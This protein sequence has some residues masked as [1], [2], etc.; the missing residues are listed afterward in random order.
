MVGEMVG[1]CSV[2]Q[3]GMR[4]HANLLERLK[5]AIDRGQRQGRTTVSRDCYG[6]PIGC[7]M[8]KNPDGIDDSLPLPGQTH[9]PGP[10]PLAKVGHTSEPT[11][12]QDGTH[13][14]TQP[15]CAPDLT[16]FDPI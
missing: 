2:V 1:R 13:R 10:Q 4:D 5:V 6:Q 16:P 11:R 12:R 9:A 8:T 14:L 15:P 7:R 3:V